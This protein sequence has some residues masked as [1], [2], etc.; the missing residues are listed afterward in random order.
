MGFLK[1]LGLMQRMKKGWHVVSVFISESRD[2]RN[3]PIR[4][5]TR[6]FASTF[7]CQMYR[8]CKYCE[9]RCAALVINGFGCDEKA[10]DPN[11]GSFGDDP[12]VDD[13]L[14]AKRGQSIVKCL[15]EE[16]TGRFL[17]QLDQI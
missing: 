1:S 12:G 5:G 13:S 2:W 3:W 9:P 4:V 6:F 16:F 15:F 7:C 17:D 14:G 11:A 10:T 8:K